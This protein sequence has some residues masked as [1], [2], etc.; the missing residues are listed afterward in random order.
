MCSQRFQQQQFTL[1]ANCLRTT[2][3]KLDYHYIHSTVE[4]TFNLF[5]KA[6]CVRVPSIPTHTVK[7]FVQFIKGKLNIFI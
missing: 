7:Q 5:L 4:T 3:G 1:T 2:T 6:E